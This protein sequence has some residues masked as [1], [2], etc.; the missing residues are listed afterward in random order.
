MSIIVSRYNLS[1]TFFFFNKNS[2]FCSNGIEEVNGEFI[3]TSS[4]STEKIANMIRTNLE[5]DDLL[6]DDLIDFIDVYEKDNTLVNDLSF[7]PESGKI[8]KLLLSVI[9]KKVIKQKVKGEALVQM[10]SAF[11]D[12]YASIPAEL[13]TGTKKQRDEI[14]KKYVGTNFLPTYHRKANGFTAAMKVMI[15]MQGD[16]LKLFNLEYANDETIGVYFEDGKLDMNASLER[17]NEKIKD[18]EWLDDNNEA[19]RKAITMMGVRIPVQGLNS[20][21]FMEVYHFLPPQAGNIIIPPAEIVAKSG[22]DY[23]IDKLTIFMTNLSEDGKVKKPEYNTYKDFKNQYEFMKSAGMSSGEIQMFFEEQ[24][25]GIENELIES[26]KGILELPDNY[27]SL[28]TPN[29]NYI[30]EPLAEEL[31]KYVMQYDPFAKV[32]VA[33]LTLT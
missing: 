16:Y 18:D 33:S 15:S 8:E 7:H 27:A 21:E 2:F 30:L 12:N 31:S 5:K 14:V 32:F 20:M 28:I 6:S 1:L 29:S 3:P 24:K 11:F 13:T 22:A 26:M 23:D 10:S 9:N 17:L 25:A 4:A 19:N